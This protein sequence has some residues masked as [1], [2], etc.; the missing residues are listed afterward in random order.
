MSMASATVPFLFLTMPQIL[1]NASLIAAGRPEAPPPSRGRARWP[2]SSEISP[3][4]FADKGELSASVVQGAGVC[5]TGALL[6]QITLAG[7]I[8]VGPF[9]VAAAASRRLVVS[10]RACSDAWVPST[11]TGAVR[12]TQCHRWAGDAQG[13]RRRACRW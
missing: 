5:A 12:E 7:H 1:K 2:A 8:P 3:S 9:V 11:P 13:R 6:T 4:Y 10:L